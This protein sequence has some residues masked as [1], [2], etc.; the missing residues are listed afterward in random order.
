VDAAVHEPDRM[1]RRTYD[2]LYRAFRSVYRS[3]R[4]SRRR[5][6]AVRDSEEAP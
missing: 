3:S 5:L 6:A 4:R 2:E 1:R